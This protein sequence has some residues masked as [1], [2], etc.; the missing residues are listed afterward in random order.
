M[1]LRSVST[2][3][4]QRA[5]PHHALVRRCTTSQT[6]T[7]DPASNRLTAL[8]QQTTTNR[9]NAQGN[10]VSTQVNAQASYPADAA[11]NLS[12]DGLRKPEH[13]VEIRVNPI[14]P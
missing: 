8:S 7:I 2:H 11:G 13:P 3:R 1:K 9:T 14:F 6:W 5:F 10:P 4:C 12:I